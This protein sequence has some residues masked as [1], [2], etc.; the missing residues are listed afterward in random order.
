MFTVLLGKAQVEDDCGT[1]EAIMPDKMM[2]E[3]CISCTPYEWL[4]GWHGREIG[5]VSGRAW[6]EIIALAK[7]Q[8]PSSY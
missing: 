1:T 6:Q 3:V 7:R 5:N 2:I 4:A 8:N